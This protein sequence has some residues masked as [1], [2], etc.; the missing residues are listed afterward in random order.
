[1]AVMSTRG[2][3]TEPDLPPGVDLE[4]IRSH[5]TGVGARFCYLHGSRTTGASTESSDVD[6]AAW[7]GRPVDSVALAA[8]LPDAVDLLVLDTAPLE[9]AGRVALHGRLLFEQ[10]PA[11]RVAWEATTRKIYLD[12]LPRREQARRDFVQAR[13]RG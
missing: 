4:A 6:L 5:L 11:S 8:G 3:A 13:L 2:A 1:M 12:E 7:F 10:D 9:L